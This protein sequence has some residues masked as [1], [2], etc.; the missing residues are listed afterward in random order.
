MTHAVSSKTREHALPEKLPERVRLARLIL[1]SRR[2][3]LAVI[4]V[5]A[6]PDNATAKD[7]V[8]QTA[9]G[10]RARR[11]R[12]GGAPGGAVY[13]D[14]R[15]L[16]ALTKLRDRFTFRVSE[17]AGGRHSPNSRH[18]KG[19]A[20]DVDIIDGVGVSSGNRHVEAF[21]R[22]CRE[23]GAAFVIGPGYDE[24]HATH[25]HAQWNPRAARSSD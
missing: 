18:Y 24:N 1:R 11:S 6:G 17:I 10:R 19:L 14:P 7:N 12:Y 23:L 20:F 22:R 5:E 13:L 2:I 8:R 16:H 15:V 9:K 4:H 3:T 25:V 21:K